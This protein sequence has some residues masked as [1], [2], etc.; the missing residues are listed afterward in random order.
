MDRLENKRLEAETENVALK[1]QLDALRCELTLYK[2]AIM[3]HASCNHLD[4]TAWIEHNVACLPGRAEEI[5]P[6]LMVG[7]SSI[8]GNGSRR[9]SI[10]STLRSSIFSEDGGI[11]G[12]S[13]VSITSSS[14]FSASPWPGRAASEGGELDS[15]ADP[16][17]GDKARQGRPNDV[18]ASSTKF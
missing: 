13:C 6:S 14:S 2:H 4:V 9:G 1:M 3:A 12:L 11:E 5:C 10:G 15:E 7:T 18:S 16:G 8:D 17:F